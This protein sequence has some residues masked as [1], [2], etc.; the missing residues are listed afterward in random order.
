MLP[1][2][3]VAIE[4]IL[5]PETGALT[6]GVRLLSPLTFT[7]VSPDAPRPHPFRV[8]IPEGFLSDGAS[9]PRLFWRLLSPPID[10][11]TI[12]PS[13]VHD[14]LYVNGAR[15]GMDREEVDR[16]YANALLDNGYPLWKCLLTFYGVRL[17]GASHWQG[18]PAESR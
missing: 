15:M 3:H 5:D 10:P 18:A 12:T 16:W 1:A 2:P 7:Y 14:Y 6:K 17:G 13:L 8:T 11:V 4:V 9:V